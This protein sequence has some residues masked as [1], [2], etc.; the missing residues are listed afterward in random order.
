MSLRPGLQKRCSFVC[1]SQASVEGFAQ[2]PSTLISD[3]SRTIAIGCEYGPHSRSSSTRPFH[4]PHPPLALKRRTQIQCDR[5]LNGYAVLPHAHIVRFHA[6]GQ[7]LP[8]CSLR[9][10]RRGC[11]LLLYLSRERLKASFAHHEK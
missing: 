9:G 3:C 1:S 7:D 2:A 10:M 8:L 5:P 4:G 6:L 11:E